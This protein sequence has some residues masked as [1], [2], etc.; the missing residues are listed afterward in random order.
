[1]TIN[2]ATKAENTLRFMLRSVWDR[3][4]L[5][6]DALRRTKQ[7]PNAYK[8]EGCGTVFKLRDVHVDHIKPVIDPDKGWEGVQ[9]FVQRLFCPS[10]ELQVLCIDVCHAK[11]TETENK[12]RRETKRCANSAKTKK[13]DG[14]AK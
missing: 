4:F 11:K 9:M 8:C 12:K 2:K 10:S 6:W 1:M 7:G 14:S 13:D 5:K 3:S